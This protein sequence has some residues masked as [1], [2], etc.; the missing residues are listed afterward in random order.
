MTTP[1]VQP[2]LRY[3]RALVLFLLAYIAI[4]VIATGFSTALEVVMHP[5]PT[6]DKIHSPSYIL[7]ERF[8][9]LLNF[10]IWTAFGRIYFGADADSDDRGRR[11]AAIRLGALWLALA[12]VADFVGFV[13]IEHPLSLSARDFYVGQFPWIYLIYLVVFSGPLCAAALRARSTRQQT[14][15]PPD[16]DQRLA[17]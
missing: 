2:E 1:Q 15:A 13:L 3:G 14:G 6:D 4:T 5:P 10:F 16:E 8:Y 17:G 7:S 9:P 12:L 11:V